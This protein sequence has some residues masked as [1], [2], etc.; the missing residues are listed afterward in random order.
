MMPAMR[1]VPST[2]PSW[3]C[4]LTIKFK[5]RLAHDDAAF[6]QPPVASDGGLGRHVDIRASPLASIWVRAE[7]SLEDLRAMRQR[8]PAA[9]M[10]SPRASKRGVAG[11]H[12]GLPHQAFRRP[13]TSTSRPAQPARSAGAKMPLSPT[14]S[15]SRGISGA[16]ASLS[17]AWSRGAKVFDVDADHRER[18]F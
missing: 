10:A 9:L 2:S 8:V 11:R 16:S 3:R 18:S 12:I 5:R 17:Q 1:A 4:P 15:R 7:L 13:G 6:G 14:I